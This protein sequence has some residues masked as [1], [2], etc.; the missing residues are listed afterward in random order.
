MIQR[1]FTMLEVLIVL[2]IISVLV[3]IALPIY[4]GALEKSNVGAVNS[5]VAALKTAFDVCVADNRLTPATCDFGAT[6]S[7]FQTP[8][9]NTFNG[10]A[11]TSGGVPVATMQPDGSGS[12]KAT[13][14]GNSYAELAAAGASITYARDTDGNWSCT[15]DLVPLKFVPLGCIAE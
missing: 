11:P 15:T 10:G 5:E 3:A 2:A 8:G 9:G 13:F 7:K 12:L 1:G 6:S 14:G 4:T